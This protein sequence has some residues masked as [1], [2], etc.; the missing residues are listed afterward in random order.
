MQSGL[1]SGS[2]D[3]DRLA[4]MD[5]GDWRKGDPDFNEPALT[6]NLELAARLEPI[7]ERHGVPVAAVAVAWVTAQP[8]VTAAIVGARRP[9]QLNGWLP[10]GDLVLSGEDLDEID[11][12]ISETGAGRD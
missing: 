8:G 11:R 1:L 2:F 12:I 7:A 3:R 9:S 6:A 10:A 5:E 4:S